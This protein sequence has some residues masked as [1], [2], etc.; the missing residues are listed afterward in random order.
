MHTTI[1]TTITT[2]LNL[3]DFTPSHGV[4][5]ECE[6][7]IPEVV[8]TNAALGGLKSAV[9]ALGQQLG[10]QLDIVRLDADSADQATEVTA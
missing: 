9:V 8:V 7:E 5:I 1:T 6:D 4:E 10:Q 2:R 3:T